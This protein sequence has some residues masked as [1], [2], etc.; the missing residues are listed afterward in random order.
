MKYRIDYSEEKNLIL[1]ETRRVN[2]EDVVDSL[3][4]GKILDNIDHFNKKKYPNQKI[5]IVEIKKYAYAV[6]YVIDKKRKV[7][8]LKT[9][10]PNRVLKEKYLKRK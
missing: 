10:Y 5:F 2:F 9:V 3:E 1:K 6:P 8:F 4:K 7:I